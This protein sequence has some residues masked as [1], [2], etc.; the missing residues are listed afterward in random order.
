MPLHSVPAVLAS[1]TGISAPDNLGIYGRRKADLIRCGR[2]LAENAI[3]SHLVLFIGAGVSAGAGLPQ[4]NDLLAE[5][6]KD[7]GMGSE[8]RK[9]LRDKDPRD[10]ATIL[11]GRLKGHDQT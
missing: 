2:G 3:R 11:E 9:H 1:A 7:A 10:Q 4:W 8:S 5:V 6:A